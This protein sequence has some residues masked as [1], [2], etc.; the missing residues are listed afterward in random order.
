MDTGTGRLTD[1]MAILYFI[2]PLSSSI[3]VS[4]VEL[5]VKSNLH[6]YQE[7][8]LKLQTIVI[9]SSNVGISLELIFFLQSQ[10]VNTSMKN[11]YFTKVRSSQKIPF[12]I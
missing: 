11:N 1:Y 4:S 2:F 12:F 8:Y 9:P 6:R 10:Y 3:H 5:K 7:H